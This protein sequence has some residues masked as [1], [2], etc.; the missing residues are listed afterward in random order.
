VPVRVCHR[1][2]REDNSPTYIGDGSLPN[3]CDDAPSGRTVSFLSH[4][5]WHPP[6]AVGYGFTALTY[7]LSFGLNSVLVRFWS[8]VLHNQQQGARNAWYTWRVSWHEAT[9]ALANT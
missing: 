2:R 5:D 7:L 6:G 3:S 1:G 4:L 9:V 8:E